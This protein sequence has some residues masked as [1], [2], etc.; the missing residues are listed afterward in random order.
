M[1][2]DGD[3]AKRDSLNTDPNLGA[4]TRTEA[5]DVNVSKQ[6]N[7]ARAERRYGEA[8]KVLEEYAAAANDDKQK[9]YA[10]SQIGA[11]YEVQGDNVRALESYHKA[12]AARGGVKDV[13]IAM[14]IARTSETLGD[15]QAAIKYYQIYVDLL[16]ADNDEMAQPDIDRIEAKLKVLKGSDQGAGR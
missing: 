15:R 10:Y 13:G 2:P 9:A 7:A 4:N 14:G 16:K 5:I 1:G 12:E 8:V 6:V 3:D 11:V